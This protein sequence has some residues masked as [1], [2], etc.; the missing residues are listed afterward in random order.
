MATGEG[1]TQ[2]S[3]TLPD[4]VLRMFE[5][6]YPLGLYGKTRAEVARQLILDMMKRLTSENIVHLRPRHTS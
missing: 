4:E 5:Q 3:V 2:F 6:L 1:N